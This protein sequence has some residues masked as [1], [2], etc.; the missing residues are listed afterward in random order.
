[1]SDR[2]VLVVEDERI[3]A[4]D[5]KNR[6]ESL[7]YG[8]CG[9]VHSGEEAVARANEYR[10]DVVLMDIM[11]EGQ[12]DGIEAARLIQGEFDIPVIFLTA[13]SD[14]MTI[15]RAK[16]SEPY[17]YIL[18]PFEGR[19]IHTVVEMALYKHGMESRLKKMERWLSTTLKSIGDAVL[20]TDN[21]GTVTFMNPIAEKLTGWDSSEVIGRELFRLI[22]V[23]DEQTREVIDDPVRKV[24]DH[25]VIVQI[26]DSVLVDRK[27]KGIPVKFSA[28]P[29]QDDHGRRTGVVLVINDISEQKRSAAE[30]A[31]TLTRLRGAMN[32]II[33][34][35]AF[36][37][38]T[39][40]PYTAGHQRRVTD[41]ARAIA[42]ELGLSD[43]EIDGIR[44]AGVIHDL[45]KISIPAEIL[46]KPG[47]LSPI[48]FELIKT[49]PRTGYEILK[50]IDFPWPVAQIVFQHHEKMDG[51]GYPLGASGSDILIE[52]RVLAVADV[53]EAIASHRPYRA[54]LGIEKSLEEI[55]KFRGIHFDPAVVDACVIL[56]TERG[57]QF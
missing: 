51:S 18:K 50:N 45:G 36:T 33:E 42:G 29:I 16:L 54:A 25:G 24:L 35:M 34:A 3:V 7:G 22:T 21:A 57:F 8:I 10:P 47:R 2:K 52:S 38:E 37:V 49:H 11:L 12:M 44:M 17:G 40:D 27:G 31:N 30:T 5:I 26:Y 53:V 32:S 15:Q 55:V 9:I 46:S 43:D 56:F 14:E 28:A 4:L 48:E 23:L 20:A 39:R 19:D 41:L 1:M 13:Y 6:L